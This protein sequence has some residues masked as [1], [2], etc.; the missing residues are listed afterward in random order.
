MRVSTPIHA[1]L[2]AVP[3]ASLRFLDGIPGIDYGD[4]T[5]RF[6]TDD[7]REA[8]D[9]L[10]EIVGLATLGYVSVLQ[11]VVRDQANADEIFEAFGTAL[12][13]R[14]FDQESGRYERPGPGSAEGASGRQYHGYR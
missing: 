8:Y 1:G 3:P 10:V 5:L 14:W 4:E 7:L 6:V 11:E 13:Q 2:H 9:G 12:T